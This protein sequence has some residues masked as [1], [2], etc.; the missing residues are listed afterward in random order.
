MASSWKSNEGKSS[1]E[2]QRRRNNN[3]GENNQ[4]GMAASEIA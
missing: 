1:A 2:R 4:S 3:V